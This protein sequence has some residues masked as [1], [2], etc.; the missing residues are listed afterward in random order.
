MPPE[1]KIRVQFVK[2]E[3]NFPIHKKEKNQPMQNWQAESKQSI[4]ELLGRPGQ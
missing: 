3:G 1:Y 4:Y 2:K